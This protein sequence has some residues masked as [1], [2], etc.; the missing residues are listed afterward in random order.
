[1]TDLIDDDPDGFRFDDR[2]LAPFL[3]QYEYF[4][5]VPL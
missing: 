5:E 4:I 2:L 3:G 1:M